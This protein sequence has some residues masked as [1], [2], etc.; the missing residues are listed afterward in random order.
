MDLSTNYLKILR[1][2]NVVFTERV[3]T[4]EARKSK[5]P[6]VTKIPSRQSIPVEAGF[7]ILVTMIVCVGRTRKGA[8]INPTLNEEIQH[9]ARKQP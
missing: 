3:G 5:L 8:V 1:G 2:E 4:L 9:P 7:L 6:V